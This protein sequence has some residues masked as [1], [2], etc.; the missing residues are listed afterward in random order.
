MSA[1][2]NNAVTLVAPADPPKREFPLP[3]KKLVA[4]CC[5]AADLRSREAAFVRLIRWIQGKDNLDAEMARL[6]SLVEYLEV[7]EDVRYRMGS[8]YRQLLQE[9]RFV[10]VFAETGVPSDHAL[11]V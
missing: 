6:A 7:D 4:G 2:P 1:P 8:S 9:L 10:S 3:L 5:D 11:A